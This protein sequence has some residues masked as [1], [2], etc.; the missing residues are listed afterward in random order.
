MRDALVAGA[1]AHYVADVG[2]GNRE[3]V[4]LLERG[5]NY[6]WR[7]WEGTSCFMPP[8]GGC[9][10]D[11]MTF[12]IA[13]YT[14][15]EGKS[16]TGG[17]AYH[18]AAIPG[19][20]G[21]YLYADYSSG[22]F[23]ALRAAT[24]LPAGTPDASTEFESTVIADA[25][26]AP[27][28][29]GTDLHGEVYVMQLFANPRIVR[30]DAAGPSAAAPFPAT[31]SATACFTELATLAPAPGLIPYHVNATLWSDGAE[32]SRFWVPPGS[33]GATVP[34]DATD[35]W[36]FPV[37]TV[38]V[39]HFALGEAPPGDPDW[40]PVETRFEVRRADGWRFVTYAWRNDRSDADLLH[41]GG[42]RLFAG[43]AGGPPHEWTYPS[44]Q[45]CNAC[46]RGGGAPTT[47]LGPSSAQLER[48]LM[49]G[50]AALAPS[51]PNSQVAAALAAGL[52]TGSPTGPGE[53]FPDLTGAVADDL[54]RAAR[55][56]L[57]VQCA[58][59]HRPGGVAPSDLDLRATADLASA[60]CQP[61]EAGDLGVP[62][63]R[64]LSPGSPGQSLIYLRLALDPGH[65]AF[66]PN[67]GVAIP[68]AEGLA[69]IAEWIETGMDAPLW[70]GP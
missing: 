30:L 64:L 68:D 16:I 63:A 43:P 31:L 36:D 29:F 2:Q 58:S 53:A 37:G 47:P 59:C 49:P 45:E 48:A 34:D 5:V 15:A 28:S 13:E 44:P 54:D 62:G 27:V 70:S 60:L 1:L 32:K 21:A 61:P 42:T 17:V 19:M 46:H 12:P 10:P 22:R 69:L 57:H 18:G 7:E 11:G 3:E 55:T 6:G 26:F 67:L 52:A 39:K 8:A 24:G 56:Y 20:L 25:A 9:S 33:G 38:L 65:E 40:R 41:A 51:L 66:M 23:W 50:W 14:H 35:V 4:D